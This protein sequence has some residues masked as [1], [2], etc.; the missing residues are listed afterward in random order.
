MTSKYLFQYCQKLVIL[1]NDK[2]AV[3]LARRD[4]EADYDGVFSFIGGKM[5]TSDSSLVDGM[6]REKDE[7]IGRGVVIKILPNETYNKYF[8]KKDGSCMVLPH[9]P[10]YFKSGDIKLSKEYSELKWVPL[11]DLERFE[12]KIDGINEIAL[13]AATKVYVANDSEFIEI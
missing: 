6:K 1:S 13:W 7:E 10:G 5:E 8:V 2:Q 3:L 12:P 11:A 4:G 9:I